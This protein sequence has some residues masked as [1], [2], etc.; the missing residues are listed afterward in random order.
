MIP[1]T[2]DERLI[3]LETLLHAGKMPSD[4][5]MLWAVRYCRAM[6]ER[7]TTTPDE[8]KVKALQE[9]FAEAERQHGL[10]ALSDKELVVMVIE[11]WWGH[12]D[13]HSKE[14][15]LLDNLLTRLDRAGGGP[16]KADEEPPATFL[17]D[18]S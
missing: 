17:G 14:S 8:R 2:A 6:H 3:D 12:M 16:I 10:D 5:E 13:S 9:L 1:K 18:V 11:T 4:A 15:T 7:K